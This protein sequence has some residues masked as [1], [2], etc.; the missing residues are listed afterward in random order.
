MMDCLDAERGGGSPFYRKGSTDRMRLVRI[1]GARTE[2][3]V[4]FVGKPLEVRL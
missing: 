4:M 2:R 1:A 3:N